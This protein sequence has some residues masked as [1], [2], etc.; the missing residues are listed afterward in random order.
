MDYRGGRIV[1]TRVNA[2]TVHCGIMR[3]GNKAAEYSAPLAEQFSQ[4]IVV[5]YQAPVA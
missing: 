1:T 5:A 3:P 2:F 4:P